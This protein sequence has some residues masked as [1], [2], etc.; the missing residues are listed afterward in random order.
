MTTD[1][2]G[3]GDAEADHAGADHCGA[4][5]CGAD[6]SGTVESAQ[7]GAVQDR[8]RDDWLTP[9]RQSVDHPTHVL[10]HLSDTHLTSAGIRYNGVIDADAALDRAVAV[11]RAAVAEGRR[12][13]AVVVSGDLTDSGDPDAYHRLEAA[14]G[15][16]ALEGGAGISLVFATGNHDVRRQFHRHL[17]R[18]GDTDDT[19]GPILQ[20]QA[21]RGLRIIV[22]DSTIPSHGHGRLLPEHLDALRDELRT[23][24]EAGTVVVLHHAP[25]PPPSPLL[26]YFAL[27][28]HSRRA[29]AAAVAGTDV[30]LI[31]AGHHHLPQSGMLGAVPVAVAGSTAIRT[32]PMGAAG[33][34]RTFQDGAFNLVELFIDTVTVSVVP[35]SDA[36][37]VFDLD[38]AGCRAVIDAH[39]V[40]AE[41][42]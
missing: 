36:P 35:V 40:D 32:D 37:V 27:E 5:H 34:E 15:R 3:P 28:T 38:A 22:L 1:R 19:D 14:F 7:G 26:S 4:D 39:P 23:P 21:V 30:R 9:D 20:V 16:V 31:L 11:L 42:R 17:L 25:L 18:L 6:H 24:A 33:H 10:A 8:R 13:D 12:I 29:L 41:P 2:P